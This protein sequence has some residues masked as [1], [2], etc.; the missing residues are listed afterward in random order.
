MQLL[1]AGADIRAKNKKG[2]MAQEI[3]AE[4]HNRD[5]WNSV[6]EELGLKPDGTR[7][8]RPLSEVCSRTGTYCLSPVG[9][10]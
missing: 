3:A 1:E 8:R 7:M 2:L 5:F 10:E 4:Y 6:V 9:Q